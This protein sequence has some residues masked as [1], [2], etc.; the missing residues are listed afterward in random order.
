MWLRFCF[1]EK[2]E[3]EVERRRR[4]IPIDFF[5]QSQVYQ[6]FSIERL[7]LLAHK[8]YFPRKKMDLPFIFLKWVHVVAHRALLKVKH[9]SLE[10]QQHCL[11]IL[12]KT[13]CLR[14]LFGLR[15]L[16]HMLSF[17]THLLFYNHS[18]NNLFD[19]I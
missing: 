4:H 11:K 17:L 1:R 19:S 9:E 18:I 3:E 2:E 10:Y 12:H 7:Y 14:H 6:N 8:F 13:N 16:S 5:S 15:K